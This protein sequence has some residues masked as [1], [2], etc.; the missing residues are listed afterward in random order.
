MLKVVNN[1]KSKVV[2]LVLW[3]LHLILYVGLCKQRSVALVI[4]ILS[5]SLMGELNAGASQCI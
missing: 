1:T 3:Q 4:L 2:Y 5:G